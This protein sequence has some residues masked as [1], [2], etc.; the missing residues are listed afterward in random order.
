M[1]ATIISVWRPADKQKIIERLNKSTQV[2]TENNRHGCIVWK[3]TS[4]GYP[5]MK[6]TIRDE[7]KPTNILVHR[8]VYFICHPSD[9][10]RA[11]GLE[12]SHLCHNKCCIN[13]NHLNLESKSV[14]QCRNNCRKFKY[15][16]GH[17][18]HRNCL[19]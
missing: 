5:R 6:I 12:V 15:C 4:I 19:L 9:I 11:D 3:K 8:L 13:P 2:S 17:H 14:N 1:E 16:T 10:T 18:T 7:I